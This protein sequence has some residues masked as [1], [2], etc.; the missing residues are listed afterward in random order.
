MKTAA[1]SRLGET[2]GQKVPWKRW[3]PCEWCNAI[4]DNRMTAAR[5]QRAAYDHAPRDWR[6]ADQQTSRRTGARAPHNCH[7]AVARR[8]GRVCHINHRAKTADKGADFS[9]LNRE[10][11]P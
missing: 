8:S 5:A 10:G 11:L 1:R 9:R 4:T 2:R 3:V 6:I 7:Q